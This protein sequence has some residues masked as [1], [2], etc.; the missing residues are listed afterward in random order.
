MS[1]GT[2]WPWKFVFMRSFHVYNLPWIHLPSP[3]IGLFASFSNSCDSNSQLIPNFFILSHPRF[4]LRD[5][6]WHCI[7]RVFIVLWHAITKY[8]IG[9]LVKQ[10]YQCPIGLIAYNI[11]TVLS[12]IAWHLI[13][14]HHAVYINRKCINYSSLSMEVFSCNL[15]LTKFQLPLLSIHF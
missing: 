13:R 1:H 6:E 5:I 8:I 4:F 12:I 14:D 7:G 11:T 2:S 3:F 15:F 9:C 10:W